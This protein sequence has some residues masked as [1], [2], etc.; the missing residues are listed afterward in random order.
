MT[1]YV[2][3][4]L[5]VELMMLAMTLHV[6]NYSGFTKTQR[7]WYLLTFLSVM[8]CAAAEFTVHC[9]RYD[10]AYARLLTVITTIQFSVAPLLG[11][12]FSGALGLHREAKY[13]SAFSVLNVFAEVGAAPYGLVFYFD[14]AGYHRGELFIIYELF[15]FISLIYLV[16]SMLVVG[17]RFRHRDFWTIAMVLVILIAGILPMTLYNLNITYAAIA[18]SACLCYIY[19]NDLVQQDIKA[20]LV[21][22]Q[23]QMS[24]MQEHI[25]SGLATLIEDRDMETGEHISRTSAYVKLLAEFA[26]DE[27]VYADELDERFITLLYTLAP[28]HDIGKI[29][30]PDRILRKPGK[31][32]PEEY[33][34]M[35]KHA[36]AGGTA[37]REVLSGVTDESYLSFAADIATY[38]HE[39]WDGSGYPKGLR[40]EEIPL[41]ARIMALA[42]VYVALISER[43]YKAPMPPEE[44]F[45]VIRAETGT[46]FDPHLAEVFLRHREEFEAAGKSAC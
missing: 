24:E 33:D 36:A 44:A 21:T 6:L 28:M 23:K 22:R 20:E 38:H 37:V 3:T 45:E 46:H 8:L 10:P 14:G 41:P 7:T 15:Y 43:C 32:T 9:G 39:W 5:L 16:A 19:Y 11:V 40:G 2:G 18:I 1:F 25:I 31:L 17:K 12:F 29:V 13:A 34:E 26:R 27:G 4:I 30:I 42:D 35:K